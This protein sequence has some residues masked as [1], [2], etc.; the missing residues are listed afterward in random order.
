MQRD[1]ERQ[2][3]VPPS[4]LPWV[5]NSLQ[6]PPIQAGTNTECPRLETGNS[7]VT[8]CNAPIPMA[9]AYVNADITILRSWV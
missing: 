1:D 8:P 6:V 9:W 4:E 2:Y 3:G 7:S 5:T